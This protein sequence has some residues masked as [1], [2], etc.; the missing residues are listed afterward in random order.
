MYDNTTVRESWINNYN[1]TDLSNNF[2]GQII[3]NISIAMPH[4]GVLAAAREPINN[5]MQPQDI[6]IGIVT[7][8]DPRLLIIL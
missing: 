8:S 7:S 5:I 2:N 3:N 6:T 1:M 4:A